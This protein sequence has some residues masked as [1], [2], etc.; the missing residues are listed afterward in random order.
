MNDLAAV[1]TAIYSALTTAPATYA[2]YDA[3]PQGVLK[4]YIVIGEWSGEADEQLASAT[5]DASVTLHT[6]SVLNSKAQSHAMLQF[7]RARL[8]NVTVAGSWGFSE[9]FNE[10]MEDPASTSAS[11]LYHGVARYRVRVG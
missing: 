1:Q 9:D 7:I 11:R 5:T 6:W 10:I 3:V 8:D 4:P 2:I